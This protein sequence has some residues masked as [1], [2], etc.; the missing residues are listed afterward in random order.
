V[1]DAEKRISD[2]KSELE[3]VRT[4]RE[5]PSA[6]VLDPNREQKRQAEIGR[7]QSEVTR[8]ESRLER[9]KQELADFEEEARRAGIP[10]G[11]IRQP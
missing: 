4:D 10:P 5:P 2:L 1:S 3:R 6:N 8:A 9:A 11:W 7:L